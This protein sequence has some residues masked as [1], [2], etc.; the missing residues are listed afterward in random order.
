MECQNKGGQKNST[1]CI[2]V[3]ITPPKYIV[4]LANEFTNGYFLDSDEFG[5]G[6]ETN[7]FLRGLGFEI[8]DR[9]SGTSIKTT[10]KPKQ[11]KTTFTKLYILNLT[12]SDYTVSH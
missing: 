1:Y 5:G 4:A 7:N 12:Y 8:I 10:S 9:I 3:I 2:M 11:K 6:V